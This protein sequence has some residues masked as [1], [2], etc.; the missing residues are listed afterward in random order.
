M[1]NNDRVAIHEV[2][3]QKTVK[4]D[5]AG[6]KSSFYGS[7]FIIAAASPIYRDDT[8]YQSFSQLIEITITNHPFQSALRTILCFSNK[9]SS[10][11]VFMIRVQSTGL[12]FSFPISLSKHQCLINSQGISTSQIHTIKYRPLELKIWNHHISADIKSTKASY[13]SYGKMNSGN[14]NQLSKLL[15]LLNAC[16]SNKWQQTSWAAPVICNP[17]SAVSGVE[18]VA[19]TPIPGRLPIV[20]Q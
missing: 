1:I 8:R 11:L 15:S 10:L 13:P 5:K 17:L 18:F 14:S 20:K 4:I 19:A 12:S 9:E 16:C 6:I 2:M 3:E 7:C